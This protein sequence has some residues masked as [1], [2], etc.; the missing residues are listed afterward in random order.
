MTYTHVL[1]EVSQSAYD[2][3]AT[4]LR[5][6]GYDHAFNEHGEIDMHGIALVPAD[7]PPP[8]AP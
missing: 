4:K 3:I 2:E 8:P 1:L 6:A 5:T 7:E